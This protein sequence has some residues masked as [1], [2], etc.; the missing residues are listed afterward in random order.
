VYR[1]GVSSR[2]YL[3]AYATDATGI[4]PFHKVGAR[5]V[6][7]RSLIA[8]SRFRAAQVV[9]AAA[10]AAK[11]LAAFVPPHARMVHV[12]LDLY[13]TAAATAGVRTTGDTGFE[14]G[15][16]YVKNNSGVLTHCELFVSLECNGS[17]QID[18][19]LTGGGTVDLYVV[20]WDERSV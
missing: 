19:D 17:Q 13:H 10:F 7:R 11:S 1:N 9:G 3:G 20:G 8:A 4:L 2:R 18:L 16:V 14:A 5:Y 6:Y 12:M 15:R